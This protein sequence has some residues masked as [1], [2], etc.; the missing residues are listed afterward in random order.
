M[1]S[2]SAPLS[3]GDTVLD[4]YRAVEHIANGGHSVVY[5][6]RDERL[7]RPVCI[8]VFTRFPGDPGISQTSYEHFVQ[9]AFALS[10]LTHP[11]T[12]RIYDFGHLAGDPA[13]DDDKIP[14][15]V[16]EYMN[17][18]TLSQLIR[19]RGAQPASEVVRIAMAVAD[20][21]AEAHSVGIIHRDLK[22]QNILF[23]ALGATRL[24]KL[25]DFGIAKWLQDEY[26]DDEARAGERDGFSRAG[27][28]QVVSGQKMAMYSPSWAAPEQLA[29]Q[30]VGPSADV[31]SLALMA[32]YM[33]TGRAIFTD[34]DVYEG[35]R[36]RKNGASIVDLALE[37]LDLPRTAVELLIAATRFEPAARPQKADEFGIALA[38]AFDSDRGSVLETARLDKLESID[39]T[40]APRL[41]PLV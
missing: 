32:I 20:A 30:T 10:R 5:L 3:L 31:Y 6:G 14:F 25:A 9:E 16:S 2:P 26:G 33:L 11:N 24:P 4:R 41:M 27:D 39:V 18:G 1:L 22:P 37:P 36:K 23:N 28:T 19:E 17:G 38:E 12:L 40:S 35:Y 15:H 7:A 8:K 34:D 29:G 13:H 21:L